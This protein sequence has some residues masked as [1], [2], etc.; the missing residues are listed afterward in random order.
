MV[1][2]RIGDRADVGDVP[3]QAAADRESC[4]DAAT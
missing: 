1:G 3:G 2:E 4:D